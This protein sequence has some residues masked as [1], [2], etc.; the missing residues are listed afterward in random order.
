MTRNLRKPAGD[1]L[2][3]YCWCEETLLVVAASVVRAGETQSC[4]RPS[5]RAPDG[6]QIVGRLAKTG[7]LPRRVVP[8]PSPTLR[9]ASEE[10]RAYRRAKARRLQGEGCGL[11]EIARAL[12]VTRDRVLDDLDG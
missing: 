9:R 2:E 6:S 3:V 8:R 10:R 7:R 5:C 4:G 12:G 11:D 1:E